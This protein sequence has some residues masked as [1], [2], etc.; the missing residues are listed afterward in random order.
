[1]KGALAPI[2]ACVELVV[3]GL[4]IGG[5]SPLDPRVVRWF[6]DDDFC[7]VMGFRASVAGCRGDAELACELRSMEC[8]GVAGDGLEHSATGDGP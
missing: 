2:V 5:G 7:G 4:L 8:Q 3:F 6:R 1:M